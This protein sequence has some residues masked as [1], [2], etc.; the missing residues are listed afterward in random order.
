MTM[1]RFEEGTDY[2]AAEHEPPV[3]VGRECSQPS[4][5]VWHSGEQQR[6]LDSI[7][8]SSDERSIERCRERTAHSQPSQRQASPTGSVPDQ[9][10][11]VQL[12]AQ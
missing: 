8:L 11:T 12:F 9:H 5:S 10:V 7:I 4:V 6:R 1:W 2:S 3:T